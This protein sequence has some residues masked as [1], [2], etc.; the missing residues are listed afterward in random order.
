MSQTKKLSRREFL[1]LSAISAAG[2]VLAACAKET[3]APPVVEATKPA[4]VAATPTP[5]PVAEPTNTPVPTAAAAKEAPVLAQ[6]VAEGKLPPL[7]ER[8][9]KV[10]LTLAPVD[11][12]GQYGGRIRTMWG[13]GWIGFFL[14]QQYGHSPLRWVDD[15]LGIA[16][17]VC[18]TWSANADN[19]EW[20]LHIREG[21]KWSDGQPCTVDDV[22]FWWDDLTVKGDPA[23]PDAIPDFGQDANGKLVEIIK[24]D[25]YTLVMKYGTPAP[26]TAKRLAMWVN[27]NIGPRWIAPKHY[28]QQFHPK[29]NSEYKDFTEFNAKA[30]VFT[31]PEM[32]SLCAWVVS[33][34]EA[35][36][37]MTAERNPY[38][39]AVE[40]LGNLIHYI[41]VMVFTADNKFLT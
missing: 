11:E 23:N 41:E 10:P 3:T 4:E 20:T 40:T 33:K 38:Y 25:D 8:L 5:R 9:P 37:S 14:E 35:G 7:E 21:L 6:L 27:A 18:D 30:E 17:G 28:L 29:Y 36:V 26:L 31:N 19:S 24:V 39:Y 22:L 15:G 1:R 32:P 34:Y 13:G 16:P 12:I 2:V